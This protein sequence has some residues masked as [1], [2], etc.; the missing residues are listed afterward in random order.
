MVIGGD[1]CSKSRGF[2][3]QHRILDGH[4]QGDQM[5]TLF[6]LYLAIFNNDNLPNLPKQ[7]Q[8]FA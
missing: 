6:V 4:F 1:P 7:A 3:F 5:A 2:E 8:I